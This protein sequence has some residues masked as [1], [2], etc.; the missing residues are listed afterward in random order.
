MTQK[1]TPAANGGGLLDEFS[2]NNG[3][4]VADRQPLQ[5]IP[6]E[7]VQA[8]EVFMAPGQVVELRA[9]NVQDS[10]KTSTLSGYFDADHLEDL[11]AAVVKLK[12]ASGIYFTV[13]PVVPA[14][15][16]RCSNRLKVAKTG[17]LTTDKD[18]LARR[19][20]YVD[21]DAVRPSGISATDDEKGASLEVAQRVAEHLAGLGWPSPVITDSG[22][23][24]HLYYQIDLPAVDGGLVS[25]MLG[26]LNQIFGTDQVKVDGSVANPARITKLPGTPV[27]KGDST[28]ER[29]HRMARLLSVPESIQVVPTSFLEA[30]VAV[31]EAEKPVLDLS[32]TQNKSD[33]TVYDVPNLL[34]KPLVSTGEKVD[35]V[36]EDDYQG[37]KRWTLTCPYRP[38]D[39]ATYTIIQPEK[40]WVSSGCSH[41]T[42]D[43]TRHPGPDGK[44]RNDWAQ[45]KGLF[46]EFPS[47]NTG[48][49][50]AEE[51]T[52][53]PGGDL[54][55]GDETITPAKPSGTPLID[56]LLSGPDLS[57]L[58]IP[59]REMIV[60][61]F[62]AT[63][64]INM[65]TAPRGLGKTFFGMELCRAVTRGQPFFE[66]HVPM[67][68][69]VL[70][71][72]GE[73]PTSMLQERFSFLYGGTPSD[74]LSILP[75][76]SLWTKDKPL[77]LNE[78]ESQARVQ[79][80]L[81]ALGHQDRK[82]S[83]V[84][85]DNLSS[86]S[87]GADEN[88]NSVQDSILQ[89]LMGLRHQGY[90]ILLVHHTGKSG[91][92]RGAS[93]REDFLDT[94]I[95][96]SPPDGEGQGDGAAFKIEFTKERGHK[97]KPAFLNVALEEDEHGN[98]IWTRPNV[99]PAYLRA[100]LVIYQK[101][102]DTA[103]ALGKAMDISRAAAQKHLDRL[104]QKGY[105]HPL[106]MAFTTK[107]NKAISD[108]LR[109]YA[110]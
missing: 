106:K 71:L 14:L 66:W 94:S 90:A 109:E 67:A 28:P 58:V 13:N 73:M 51:A 35:V 74:R 95:M 18:I 38:S 68:R 50:H 59:P 85:V 52:E 4:R 88:D 20:F 81:D 104:R 86:M 107:G 44:P 82:P 55:E 80:M 97:A 43:G 17:D 24:F 34:E 78:P 83:L 91:A 77:N 1:T 45:F 64:S 3:S 40:G 39:G 89:W 23:G 6:L 76:E 79:A 31:P 41:G 29:P 42:C 21:C 69:N 12:P 5:A 105:L 102:P 37:G 84:I 48:G 61:P 47:D 72:D 110:A 87:F 10:Y 62:I 75:S 26:R 7:I 49:V 36:R 54:F 19:W 93:R 103:T 98:P 60:V 8:L 33:W 57:R 96:L 100:L 32:G 2:R 15:L 99:L 92:Q 70:F 27:R 30:L 101:H 25:K 65:V 53:D 11:A 9:L 22:N 16:A 63:G 108:L 46:G 56:L